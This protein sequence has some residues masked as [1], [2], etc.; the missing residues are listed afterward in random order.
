[1]Q[2]TG[3]LV[4]PAN[5]E[6]LKDGIDFMLDNYFSYSTSEI[7]QYVFKTYSFE[8]IGQKINKVYDEIL[9][10]NK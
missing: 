6:A 4:E 2:Q 3:I 1:M 10:K 8:S 7:R 9:A 5:S